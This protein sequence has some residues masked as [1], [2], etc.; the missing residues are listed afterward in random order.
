LPTKVMAPAFHSKGG[1]FKPPDPGDG[2]SR[3][4]QET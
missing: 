4:L 3:N 2:G 1:K